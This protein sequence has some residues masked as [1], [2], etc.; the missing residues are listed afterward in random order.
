MRCERFGA[1]FVAGL[2]IIG[3]NIDTSND[4]DSPTVSQVKTGI[5]WGS[6]LR[7]YLT[8]W[9]NVRA[10]YRQFMYWPDSGKPFLAP[11]EFTLGLAFL[12]K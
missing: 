11:V 3:A 8:R 12:T 9:L 4:G 10:D 5:H 6:T 2:G 1:N 7:F